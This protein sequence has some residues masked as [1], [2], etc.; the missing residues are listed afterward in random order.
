MRTIK[1]FDKDET[2][3]S[4]RQIAK[5]GMEEES[6]TGATAQ[7]LPSNLLKY[8]VDPS[9]GWQI[10]ENDHPIEEVRLTVNPTDNP[11]LPV[12][13]F[14]TW[15]L[16]VSSCVL[17]SFTNTFFGYRTNQL[18]VGSVC[19]QIISLPIGR[20]L[21]A[22]LPEKNI[23]LPFT[24]WSF[25]LNPGPFSIKEHCLISIFAGTGAG[26]PLGVAILTIIHAFYHRG[27]NLMAA[28]LLVQTT[29]LLGYGLAGIFR[30]YLV[31]SPYMWWPGNLVQVSLFK[32]LNQ[33]EKRKKG[34]LTRLQFFLTVF[35][36]SFAY[37]AVPGF[38][39][40]AISTIS[41]LC[42]VY[43]KS[44]TMQ[45]IGS[46][47]HGLGI[48]SFGLD[49][50]TVAGF[51]GSPFASP[52][53]AIINT[54]IS[55]FLIIYVVLPLGYWTNTYKAKHFPLISANLFDSSGQI[56]NT[57]RIINANSFTLNIHEEER[58]GRMNLSLSFAL[59]YALSFASLTASFTHVALHN[60]KDIWKMWQNTKEYG[61]EKVDDVHMR[62]MKRNYE[63]V[64]QWWFYLL[65][66][67][68]IGLSIFTCEGFN[69]QLQLPWWGVLFAAGIAFALHIANRSDLGN[70]KSGN[71][72]NVI[73]EYIVGLILP[74]KPLANVAFKAYGTISMGSALYLLSDLNLGHYMKIPP[75]A[76]FISQLA[77]TIINSSVSFAA[78]WL[79][80]NSI[81]HIC[82]PSKLPPGSPWTCPGYDVFYNASIIWGLVGPMRMFG[83][84]GH[85]SALNIFFLV[86]I[87]LPIPFWFLS[88]AFPRYKWLKYIHIPLLLSGGSGVPPIHAVNYTMWGAVGIFLTTIFT[89]D[90]RIGGQGI[91]M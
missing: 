65:L 55:F 21:A 62:L 5:A 69:G 70:N 25:S 79:L 16:G 50:S 4:F 27:I 66:F 37:Y 51:L 11:N 90:T 68:V 22:S 40:P 88:K 64:P 6:S 36:A 59:V 48:A 34:T 23:R 17:L 28:F 76:M 15:L 47:L 58:Y 19:I 2:T 29:Q 56:Y 7:Q 10:E 73:T 41:V 81:T 1:S 24:K 85:Y 89:E 31:D 74:G 57:T 61:E 83:K 39:F 26:S 75:K 87:V 32:A 63:P 45:Q 52:A 78:A 53:S 43:K 14:R 60:G 42:L 86:G 38:L 3:E 44:V 30:K 84:L 35:I 18:G 80:L 54:M 12:L 13:T 72:I 8:D 91:P 49:W 33:K 20:F 46:G 71:G 77:G 82:D 67:L 9:E